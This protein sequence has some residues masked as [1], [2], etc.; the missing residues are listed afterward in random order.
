MFLPHSCVTSYKHNKMGSKGSGSCSIPSSPPC[1]SIIP[2]S[3]PKRCFISSQKPLKWRLNDL[4]KK[5]RASL[6]FC[7]LFFLLSLLLFVCLCVFI[8]LICTEDAVGSLF[9]SSLQ[10][11]Y[12]NTISQLL[13]SRLYSS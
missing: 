10:V 13:V 7:C 5:F 12:L 1:H 9:P 11:Y 4:W 3:L 2:L 6:L 8:T